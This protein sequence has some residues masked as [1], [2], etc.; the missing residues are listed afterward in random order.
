MSVSSYFHQSPEKIRQ[1]Q[2]W[3]VEAQ[4]NPEKFAPLYTKYYSPILRYI[5]Q[6]TENPEAAL[7]IASQVFIKALNH[8]D[9]YEFRGVPFGAWLYRIAKSE[10]NQTYRDES[11]MKKVSI[12]NVQLPISLQTPFE[13]VEQDLDLKLLQ[14]CIKNLKPKQLILIEMRFFSKMSFKE[15]SE[16]LGITETNA[17]VKTF[18]VVG[19]LR[20]E[21]LSKRIAA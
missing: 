16:E 2:L 3:L 1:E 17:K 5:K 19:I 4:Q 11:V 21:L 6:R 8:L 7:D 18:R 15:M 13:F 10:L 9:S 12:E 14:N 20:E